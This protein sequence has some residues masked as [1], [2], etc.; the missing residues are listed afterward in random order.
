MVGTSKSPSVLIADDDELLLKLLEHKLGQ[1]G[2]EVTS[3]GDGEEA[4]ET[5]RSIKPDLIVLDGMMPGMNGFEVLRALKENEETRKIS[6]VMLTA[7]K[8]ERDIVSGLE[9]G[10]DEY[11]TKPFLPA[12]LIT[13]INRLLRDRRSD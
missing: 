6:V 12:E 2:Y 10:A 7:R 5:A 9:L 8:M 13:R 1:E 4:L 11:I 3:V